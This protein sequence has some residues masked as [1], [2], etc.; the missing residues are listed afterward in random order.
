[1]IY[2]YLCYSLL[3][4][5]FSCSDNSRKVSEENLEQLLKVD[6]SVIVKDVKD[7]LLLEKPYFKIKELKWYNDSK[8]SCNSVVDY[9]FLADGSFRI[10]RK[11]RLNRGLQKWERYQN[12]YKFIKN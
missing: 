11:Y 5:I 12:E 9:Y 3:F 6:L 4:F 1:M 2:R 7:S 10:E 8:Y